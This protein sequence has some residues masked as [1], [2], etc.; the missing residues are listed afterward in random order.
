VGRLITGKKS[1]V[2]FQLTAAEILPRELFAVLRM[3]EFP[4]APK[5]STAESVFN[6]ALTLLVIHE[7]KKWVHSVIVANP[8][9]QDQIPIG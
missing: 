1:A 4:S 9:Y 3:P 5:R 6:Q 2:E 7:A 8:D